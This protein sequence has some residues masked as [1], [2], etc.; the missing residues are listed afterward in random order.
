MEI[1]TNIWE[2]EQ[3]V[4]TCLHPDLKG[5]FEEKNSE[6]KSWMKEVILEGHTSKRTPKEVSQDIK[7]IYN[8][9]IADDWSHLE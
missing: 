7:H 1:N 6:D 4:V 8:V 3:E 9:E 2:Y 5:L